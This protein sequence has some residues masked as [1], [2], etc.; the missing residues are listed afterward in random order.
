MW[1]DLQF[2]D[3]QRLEILLTLL[4]TGLVVML[5]AKME[6]DWLDA[7][8]IFVLWLAQFLRPNLREGGAGAYGVWMAIL[9]IGFVVKGRPLLAP[10]YFLGTIR[11]K[12]GKRE[13]GSG[14]TPPAAAPF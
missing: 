2:D 6:F 1:L 8:A 5:L 12:P 3:A 11:Q 7:S 4:Q 10:E 14:K 9:V 13:S